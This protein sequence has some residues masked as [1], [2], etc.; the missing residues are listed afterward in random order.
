MAEGVAMVYQCANCK[1]QKVK[2]PNNKKIRV[3]VNMFR[4]LP[5]HDSQT[6]QDSRFTIKIQTIQDVLEQ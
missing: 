3:W 5:I 6:S 4:N 2:I 1:E